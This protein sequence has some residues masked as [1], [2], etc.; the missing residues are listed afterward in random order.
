MILI[1]KTSP[2]INTEELARGTLIYAKHRTWDEGR[3]GIVTHVT[4]TAI[5]VIF[6]PTVQNVLN[7]FIIKSSELNAGDWLVRYS[8]D[9]L[10]TVT[11][12]GEEEESGGDG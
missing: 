10:V 6:L 8:V 3:T 5:K 1:E 11:A 9:G 4:E 7:H 2:V 12:Y